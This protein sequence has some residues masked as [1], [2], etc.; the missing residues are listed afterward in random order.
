MES[1]TPTEKDSVAFHK[2]DIPIEFLCS[3]RPTEPS[4]GSA[5]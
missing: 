3:I 2:V 5:P 1:E 4:A